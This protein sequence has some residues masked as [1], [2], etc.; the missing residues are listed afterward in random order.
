[1]ILE[2]NIA[3]LLM[4]YWFSIFIFHLELVLEATSYMPDPVLLL[5]KFIL[6]HMRFYDLGI[7]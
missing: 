2:V 4:L 7:A 5:Q 3:D 1:M 6:V